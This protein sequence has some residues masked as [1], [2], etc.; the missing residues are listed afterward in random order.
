VKV[1]LALLIA[2]SMGSHS[3]FSRGELERVN[4]QV[5]NRIRYQRVYD[6]Q[7]H[8]DGDCKTYAITKRNILER[9]GWSRQN[10]AI[11]IV[12]TERNEEHAVLVV[13]FEEKELVLDNRYAWIEDKNVLR[14][15]GYRFLTTVNQ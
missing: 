12:L 11:W 6:W 5:N 13:Q 7:E 15:Y 9:E 8:K 4:Q 3:L 1:V 2:L 10:M 14:R